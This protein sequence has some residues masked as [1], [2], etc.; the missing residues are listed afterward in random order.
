M[1]KVAQALFGR[2]NTHLGWIGGLVLFL[3]PRLLRLTRY[4][5][6]V[7]GYLK[8]Q[9]NRLAVARD[10]LEVG[11]RRAARARADSKRCKNQSA[12]LATMHELNSR[13]IDVFLF[14]FE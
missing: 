3:A 10:P 5:Y 13:D 7:I 6:K 1:H 14:G 4:I 11:R 2:L 12:S 9:A 8:R